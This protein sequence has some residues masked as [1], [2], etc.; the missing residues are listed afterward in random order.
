MTGLCLMHAAPPRM[1]YCFGAMYQRTGF[2]PVVQT[3]RIMP[4]FAE[5]GIT[6]LFMLRPS[7]SG[8]QMLLHEVT[9]FW[10]MMVDKFTNTCRNEVCNPDIMQMCAVP[11]F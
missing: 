3:W 6:H 11:L 7:V 8:N 1:G 4:I 9:Q 5:T 2:N 10:I